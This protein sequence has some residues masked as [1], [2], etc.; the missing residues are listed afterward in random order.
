[1]G[2]SKQLD[3]QDLK[4]ISGIGN[5]IKQ[6]LRNIGIHCIDDLKGQNA[7]DLYFKDSLFKGYKDDR[8]LLYVYRLAGYYANNEIHEPERRK[9]WNWKDEKTEG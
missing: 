8:C 9:W 5:N 7:E 1:M 2:I 4:R 6:H 3:V